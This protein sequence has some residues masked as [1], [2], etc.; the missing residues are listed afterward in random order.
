MRTNLVLD[1]DLMQE[2][3]RYSRARS[4]RALVE[5]ALQTFV[6]VKAA[7]RRRESYRERMRKLDVRLQGLRLRESPSEVL[8]GYRDRR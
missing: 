1:D 8:R 7:E 4:K 5:E 2:A 3:Q 6:E